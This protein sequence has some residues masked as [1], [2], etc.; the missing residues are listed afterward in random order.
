MASVQSVS[1]TIAA[2]IHAYAWADA[3]GFKDKLDRDPLEAIKSVSSIFHIPA[4]PQLIDLDYTAQYGGGLPFNTYLDKELEQ[5]YTTGKL[6]GQKVTMT[7]SEWV[8]PANLGPPVPIQQSSSG[9]SLS[10]W[11]RIYAYI[12]Y[13][14]KYASSPD[15]TIKPHFEG[16]PADA[17]NTKIIGQ[18]NLSSP[19]LPKIKYEYR[20]TPLI[21]H[22]APPSPPGN[23][24]GFVDIYKDQNALGY[25]YRVRYCC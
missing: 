21:T 13:Q 18:L 5:I 11:A 16:D 6:N 17:L 3:T 22:D 10:D 14:A 7:P 1:L 4:N 15:K 20:K 9:I 24:Q 2:Q 8:P 19:N 12:F 23:T 25:T